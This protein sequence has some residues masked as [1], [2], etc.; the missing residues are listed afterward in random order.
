MAATGSTR[1]K[2]IPWQ[3]SRPYLVGPT[4]A[5]SSLIA[6][7]KLHLRGQTGNGVGGGGETLSRRFAADWIEAIS[8]MV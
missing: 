4:T 7:D 2:F 3:S 6:A 1:L 8:A 5:P